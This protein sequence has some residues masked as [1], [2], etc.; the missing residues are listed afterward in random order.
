MAKRKQVKNA[1]STIHFLIV[2]SDFALCFLANCQKACKKCDDIRPCSRCTKYGTEETCVNSARK[3]RRRGVKRGPYNRR[4]TEEFGET[5]E[6]SES[7][8]TRDSSYWSDEESATNCSTTEKHASG[9]TGLKIR[10]I[11]NTVKPHDGGETKAL[12]Y[13]SNADP[14]RP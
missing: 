6:E 5:D 2:Y 13:W 7:R 9:S 12:K 1:C 10:F 3:E 11:H 4:R 14:N 8:G